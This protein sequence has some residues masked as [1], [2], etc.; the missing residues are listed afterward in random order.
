[1]QYNRCIL[2]TLKVIDLLQRNC[3]TYLPS[4]LGPYNNC[5]YNT[6]PISLYQKDGSIFSFCSYQIFRVEKVSNLCVLLQALTDSFSATGVFV[7]VS[8]SCF[9]VIRSFPDTSITCI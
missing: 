5:C 6:R 2:N 4:Y 8:P 3:N 1:M 7:N 9:C